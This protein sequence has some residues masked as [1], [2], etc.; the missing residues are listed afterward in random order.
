MDVKV[1][2]EKEEIDG[3]RRDK[4]NPHD[5]V[6][7]LENCQRCQL[8]ATKDHS[9]ATDCDTVEE[10]SVRGKFLMVNGANISCA[11]HRSPQGFNPN[12]HLGDGYLD[13]IFVRHTSLFNNIRLLLAMSSKTKEIVST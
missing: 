13:L 8:A 9:N 3:G 12:C 4:N 6:R 5:G 1:Q 7:C 10:V 11:C 2:I